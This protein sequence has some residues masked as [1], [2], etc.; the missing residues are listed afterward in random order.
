MTPAQVAFALADATTFPEVLR[1][2]AKYVPLSNIQTPVDFR[3]W[4]L[5]VSVKLEVK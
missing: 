5:D 1:L 2:L 3:Q 4:L